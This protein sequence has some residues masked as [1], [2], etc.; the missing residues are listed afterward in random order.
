[1]NQHADI[2]KTISEL[3]LED[4]YVFDFIKNHSIDE[5]WFW[6]ITQLKKHLLTSTI[7][8]LLGYS[9]EDSYPDDILENKD[10][11]SV[12]S[13]FHIFFDGDG[14]YWEHQLSY[15]DINGEPI[16]LKFY[17]IK[18]KSVK[19]LGVLGAYKNITDLKKIEE[20]LAKEQAKGLE[21][22]IKFEAFTI[23]S[24]IGIYTTNIEG[25]CIYANKKWLD[26]AGMQLE[27]ALGMGWITALHP[28]DREQVSINWYKSVQLNGEWSYEYR[29]VNKENEIIWVEGNAKGLY[30]LNGELYG[31]LGTNIDITSRKLSEKL[32]RE[33]EILLKQQND[34]YIAL[35]EEL[36]VS[37]DHLIQARER[38]EESD[39][40]KSA[41]LANM[42]HEIRTPLNAIMGFSSLLADSNLEQNLR[43]E[44]IQ[45][46]DSGGKR[47][48][49]L[50]RDIVDV[51]KIDAKQL[52]LNLEI[53]NLNVII[54]N[55]QSEFAL[56]SS[57]PDVILTS[58]KGL[59]DLEGFI[60]TDQTRLIQIVSNL[61]ENAQKFTKKGSIEFGYSVQQDMLKFYVKDTGIGLNSSEQAIIFERFRQVSN[62]YSKSG[63]GT[64]LGLSIVKGLVNLF[65]GQIWVSSQP[66]IGSAFYFTIPF[67][68]RLNTEID[69]MKQPLNI[70]KSKTQYTILLAEDELSNFLY[71]EELLKSYNHK[72]IHA[73]DGREAVEMF[74]Q[75]DKINLILMDIK[76]P[77]LNG[78]DA[79]KEI[80]KMNTTVPIIAQTAYVMSEDKQKAIDAGCDDYITKPISQEVLSTYLKKHLKTIV[81]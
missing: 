41:F 77:V 67:V 35:N 38:A 43:E 45:L 64:G 36:R 25:D 51:S 80:R 20:N 68:S 10:L 40:L 71:M 52:V 59:P 18:I 37:N 9:I 3:I 49:S 65:G 30:N 14:E 31:Y 69:N 50:I 5:L 1:M 47:L 12:L 19:S 79:V 81:V 34:D 2:K 8:S 76:M 73:K 17:A 60:E 7:L 24:P 78:L 44:Y 62:E 58:S 75:N 56:T 53:C 16:C 33:N 72:I 29:F 11:E 54:D 55:L 32:K 26:M 4:D 48:L 70:L 39:N 15:T 22:K 63:A 21:S 28:D 6:D 27:E 66:E 46:I 74:K 23:Q 13:S 42:S 61:L 57:N